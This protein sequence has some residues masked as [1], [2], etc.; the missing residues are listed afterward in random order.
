MLN[1]KVENGCFSNLQMVEC[2]GSYFGM[3]ALIWAQIGSGNSSVAQSY[4]SMNPLIIGNLW[5]KITWTT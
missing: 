2:F 3:E 1:V 5:L 4:Y